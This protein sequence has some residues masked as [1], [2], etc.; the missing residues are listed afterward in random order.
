MYIRSCTH[1]FHMYIY[2]QIFILRCLSLFGCQH[3]NCRFAAVGGRSDAEHA[4][5]TS[6]VKLCLRSICSW[7]QGPIWRS[8]VSNN[9]V[10]S[11]MNEPRLIWMSHVSYDWVMSH[12]N[13]LC[14]IW[15]S[16]VSYEWVM[17]HILWV[18]SYMNRW[19]FEKRLML[20]PALEAYVFEF[21]MCGKWGVIRMIVRKR[22]LYVRKRAL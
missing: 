2:I 20:S 16:H 12:M 4:R 18:M 21:K 3:R 8:H 5:E 1:I 7:S 6:D 14:R 15:R 10:M 17:V 22:A 11:H 9:W 13:E 19:C